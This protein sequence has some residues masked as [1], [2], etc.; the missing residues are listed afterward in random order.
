MVRA[1]F[2]DVPE[3]ILADRRRRGA[4]HRDE[5]WDG[6]IHM[7]PPASMSHN[8]FQ[9]DLAFALR[10]ITDVR[11]LVLVM[12]T[13]VFEHDKSYRVPDIS[14]GTQTQSSPRGWDCAE[15][16]IEV[17]SPD[18]ESRDKLSFYARLGIREVW[19][20]DPVT[21]SFE[22]LALRPSGYLPALRSDVLGIELEVVEGPR[23]RI[24]DGATV[25]DV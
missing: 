5:V 25:I 20:V 12:E 13:G 22:I 17:L 1:L 8:K 9:I 4:D 6:V 2:L 18:D 15:L 19:L 14:I 21:R 24:R 3:E 11:N 23:L 16:V 7:V 10:R